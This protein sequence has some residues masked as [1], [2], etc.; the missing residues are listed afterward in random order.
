[1]KKY[2]AI[3]LALVMVM[4]VS[5][6]ALAWP[7]KDPRGGGHGLPGGNRGNPPSPGGGA[8]DQYDPN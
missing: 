7:I 1:M 6:A 3:A 4:S 8:G 5:S 2:F